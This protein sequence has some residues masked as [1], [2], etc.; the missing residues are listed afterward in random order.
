MSPPTKCH[1][2]GSVSADPCCSAL[3]LAITHGYLPASPSNLGFSKTSRHSPGWSGKSSERCQKDLWA[4]MYQL[5]VFSALAL[6]A[7]TNSCSSRECWG[8]GLK[9]NLHCCLL[10]SQQAKAETVAHRPETSVLMRCIYCTTHTGR[11]S[12]GLP[13]LQC[14]VSMLLWPFHLSGLSCMI[15]IWIWSRMELGEQM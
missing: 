5:S 15:N 10:K 4:R 7:G 3:S 13:Y 6:R 9:R 14:E 2:L 1:F 12:G 8:G 11:H